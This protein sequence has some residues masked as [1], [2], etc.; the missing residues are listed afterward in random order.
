MGGP[1]NAQYLLYSEKGELVALVDLSNVVL[2]R[3]VGEYLGKSVKVY[4]TAYTVGNLP[5][6]VISAQMM[7][8][9]N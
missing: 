1:I 7:Q 8:A 9:T 3:P 4:G 6:L 5:S 2:G